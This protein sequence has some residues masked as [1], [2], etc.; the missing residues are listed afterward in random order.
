[1]TRRMGKSFAQLLTSSAVLMAVGLAAVGGGKGWILCNGAVD[2]RLGGA[3]GRC[4][5]VAGAPKGTV[6][7]SG[8]EVVSLA[9]PGTWEVFCWV[10]LRFACC[11]CDWD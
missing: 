1:M 2:V 11:V 7:G 5:T 6:E 3:C 10:A 8:G 9:E 4:G